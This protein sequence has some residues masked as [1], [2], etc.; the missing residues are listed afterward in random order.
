MRSLRLLVLFLGCF[1]AAGC[2]STQQPS[3][4]SETGAPRPKGPA[5]QAPG[6]RATYTA[7]P[8][9]GDPAEYEKLQ[10]V[11]ETERGNIVLEFYPRD[12]PKTVASFVKLA[13]DGYYDGLTFHRVVP[14]F[15]VQGGDPTGTGGGGPGY[16]LPAEFNRNKHLR[17]SVAMARTQDPDS[18]G[19]Q[20]YICLEPQP[21]LDDGYTVFGMVTRGVENVDKIQQG[22]HMLKV[23]IEPR[24]GTA[25]AGG[26]SSGATPAASSAP[27]SHP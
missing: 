25:P 19:S 17:G 10:A 22:D 12:A 13:R 8:A 15:V 11:I 20:F 7:P 5:A 24:S 6:N 2:T 4:G 14:G 9:V 26:A 16:K 3:A 1:L 23:R 27:P 21:S 18:A